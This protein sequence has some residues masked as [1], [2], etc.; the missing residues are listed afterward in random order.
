MY[1]EMLEQSDHYIL[2]PFLRLIA[3]VLFCEDS[4]SILELAFH[5]V[6]INTRLVL[7]LSVAHCDTPHRKLSCHEL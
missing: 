4:G 3:S 1:V 6:L 2:D 7:P 5:I